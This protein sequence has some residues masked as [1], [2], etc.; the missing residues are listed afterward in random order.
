MFHQQHLLVEHPILVGFRRVSD[1]IPNIGIGHRFNTYISLAFSIP[2][3]FSVLA[4]ARTCSR[5]S[6]NAFRY[7]ITIS[8]LSDKSPLNF[9]SLFEVLLRNQINIRCFGR[10]PNMLRSRD[11]TENFEQPC[12]ILCHRDKQIDMQG[13]ILFY[14]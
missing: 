1:H 13:F 10:K 3:F 12:Q 7:G 9:F 11:N 6:T 4:D 5:K 14:L 8:S 2:I